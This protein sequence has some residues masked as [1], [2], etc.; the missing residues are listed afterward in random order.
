MT[1]VVSQDGRFNLTIYK[2]EDFY[3][4]CRVNDPDLGGTFPLFVTFDG[5]LYG[6]EV[7]KTDEQNLNVTLVDQ[8]N[9]TDWGA[10]GMHLTAAQVCA[11]PLT[12]GYYEIL[13]TDIT[14]GWTDF[15]ILWGNFEVKSGVLGC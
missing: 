2:G 1:T 12:S 7:H 11:L 14:L 15:R 6:S 4:A 10:F 5:K 3:V 8:M 13:A 9:P